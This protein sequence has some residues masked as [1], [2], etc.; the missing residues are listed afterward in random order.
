MSD[1]LTK[2]ELQ[3]LREAAAEHRMPAVEQREII[4]K[5]GLAIQHANKIESEAGSLKGELLP[6]AITHEEAAVYSQKGQLMMKD[7]A[8][9][10]LDELTHARLTSLMVGMTTALCQVTEMDRRPFCTDLASNVM[11]VAL[12]A[13][14]KD[15]REK[16]G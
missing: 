3:R 13:A 15:A 12:K 9:Y 5:L 10:P 16:E 11:F 2:S 6:T 7:A 8:P 4:R 14:Y 1:I